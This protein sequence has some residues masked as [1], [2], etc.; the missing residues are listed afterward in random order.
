MKWLLK[1][2][3]VFICTSIVVTLLLLLV[4]VLN[5]ASFISQRGAYFEQLEAMGNQLQRQSQANAEL[6][7]NVSQAV[8]T[9]S[10]VSIET[11]ATLNKILTAMTDEDLLVNAF[12]ISSQFEETGSGVSSKLLAGSENMIRLGLTAGEQRQFTDEVKEAYILAI[13]GSN[14][15]TK[16]YTNDYGSWYSYF[17]PVYNEEGQIIAI[18]VLDYNN[19]FVKKNVYKSLMN[20]TVICFIV[21]VLFGTITYFVAKKMFRPIVEL[22][23]VA[24][25]V[26]Q[27]DLTV[28][29]PVFFSE[30]EIGRMALAFNTMVV[31]LREIS[32]KINQTTNQLVES[33][34]FV[35]GVSEQ[36]QSSSNNIAEAIVNVAEGAQIQQVSAQES[37]R[38]MQEMAIGIQRIAESFSIVSELATE[39]TQLAVEGQTVMTQTIDQMARIEQQVSYAAGTMNQLTESTKEIGSIVSHIN[40]ITEQTNLLSLNASIEAAR[41]GEYGRGFAVVAAEIRKL[42]VNSKQASNEIA[43]ILNTIAKYAEDA[44][45]VLSSSAKEA[46]TGTELAQVTGQSLVTIL[47]SIRQVTEQVQDVS[48]ASEEMSA[49]SQQIAASLVELDKMAVHSSTH[50][51]EVATTSQQQYE[52]IKQVTTSIEQLEVLSHE[53]GEAVGKFKLN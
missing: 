28:E 31:S 25:V 19:A 15:L 43:V 44:Y 47:Q 12:Y 33:S 38:S 37:Q 32:T 22:E 20:G 36:L 1:K 45:N 5:I 29:A 53:L 3:L 7:A 39:S 23:R 51:S 30:S 4:T 17:S 11:S 42:A 27:G 24:R 10:E 35:K 16:P 9:D 8:T 21:L 18:Q 6:I 52:M 14:T 49:G 40:D 50:S 46:Q 2:S 34:A 48:A 41:A 26:A 13:N